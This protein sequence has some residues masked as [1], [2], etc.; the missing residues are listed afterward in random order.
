MAKD[1]RN[2]LAEELRR[3]LEDFRRVEAQAEALAADRKRLATIA[4]RLLHILR[5]E[6]PR[7]AE[8]LIADLGLADVIARLPGVPGR[9]PTQG[10]ARKARAVPP[11]A[12]RNAEANA[13]TTAADSTPAK[14]TT[15][16]TPLAKGTPVRMLEGKYKG[17]TGSIRW[18]LVQGSTI[19][20][21]VNL[22]SDS[23]E[24]SRNQVRHGSLGTTWVQL[25]G[26]PST[27]AAGRAAARTKAPASKRGAS[28]RKARGTTRKAA[29]T[30]V[31]APPVAPPPPA[32]E[33]APRTVRRRRK[34][35]VPAGT[36]EAA[37]KAPA[38]I[39][40]PLPSGILQKGTPIKMLTGIYLG[41][42][43]VIASVQAIPGPKPDA[44]YTLALKGPGGQKGRTSVK[45]GSLGRTWTRGS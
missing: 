44:V 30:T 29:A 33:A 4:Q 22:V 41:F 8:R 27:P 28:G 25:P 13:R 5:A 2:V 11:R 20:Y 38:N 35:A 1:T 34:E 9:K 32:T 3:I 36:P 19:S 12:P 43:G 18:I 14:A 7:G 24:K 15:A 26:A 21:T 6:A 31:V 45:Q 23:G 16:P 37:V 40:A 42:T 10:A 39:P 17:W